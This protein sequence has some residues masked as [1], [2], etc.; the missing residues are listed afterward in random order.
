MNEMLVDQQAAFRK[1]K[2]PFLSLQISLSLVRVG[3]TWTALY[4]T[5]TSFNLIL[6]DHQFFLIIRKIFVIRMLLL[7]L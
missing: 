7:L 5:K 6:V 3:K 1:N 4:Y 2:L